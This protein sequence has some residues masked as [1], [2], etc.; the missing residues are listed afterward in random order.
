MITGQVGRRQRLPPRDVRRAARPCRVR[1]TDS[2]QTP[3]SKSVGW[4]R[5]TNWATRGARPARRGSGVERGEFVA[6]MG[7]SGSGKSTLMNILGCLDRPSGG[8]YARR[9]RCH[10]RRARAGASAPAHRL[11]LSELQSAG[12]NERARERRVAPAVCGP[13][14]AHAR[15]KQ[16]L[17]ALGLGDASK[18]PSQ[19][20]GGQQREWPSRG[21]W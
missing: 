16:A 9:P 11:C 15:A 6:I 19:L 4:R 10:G 8:Q 17:R 21:H 7:A 12:A 14:A 18:P 13:L 1:G 20:S 5:S 2:C 3:S